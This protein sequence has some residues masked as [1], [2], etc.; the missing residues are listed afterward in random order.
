MLLQLTLMLCLL[1]G[2][3]YPIRTATLFC[4]PVIT[5]YT[6]LNWC[7]KSTQ[8]KI[9]WE[10]F[11]GGFQLS[12]NNDESLDNEKFICVIYSGPPVQNL[13]LGKVSRLTMATSQTASFLL[14]LNVGRG[15]LKCDCLLWATVAHL[16]TYINTQQVL[17]I[18]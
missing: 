16:Y 13:F 18:N 17:T 14:N 5:I 15:N 7:I 2:L 1:T 11:I 4:F 12:L 6:A 10:H 8:L 9:N 3:F